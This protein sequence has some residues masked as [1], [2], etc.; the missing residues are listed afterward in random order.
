[1]PAPFGYCRD[2]LAKAGLKHGTNALV[3]YG[4]MVLEAARQ[5]SGAHLVK[6]PDFLPRIESL[7]GIAAVRGFGFRAERRF[8][9]LTGTWLVDALAVRA[10]K[11]ASTSTDG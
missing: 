7:R 8:G 4:P 3:R 2:T 1:V 9:N 6:K 10:R 5:N 11:G